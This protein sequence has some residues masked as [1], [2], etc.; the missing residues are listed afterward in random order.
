M[1]IIDVPSL[2]TCQ[3]NKCTYLAKATLNMVSN[4]TCIS[5]QCENFSNDTMYEQVYKYCHPN[6]HFGLPKRQ[7]LK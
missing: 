1:K 5:C 2:D 4:A 6:L 7:L 3:T